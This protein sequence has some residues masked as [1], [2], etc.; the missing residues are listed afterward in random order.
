MLESG[1]GIRKTT[2][3]FEGGRKWAKIRAKVQG[4]G[5]CWRVGEVLGKR[6][7]SLK[8]LRSGENRSRRPGE[9]GIRKSYREVLERGKTIG[10]GV[11][12]C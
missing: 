2:E 9:G 6:L 5:R 7:R 4:S 8:V 3:K 1:G 11:G 12:G 10:L